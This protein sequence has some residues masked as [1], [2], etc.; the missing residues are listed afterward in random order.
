MQT[1]TFT[2]TATHARH[3]ASK[4]AADLKRLQRIYGVGSPSDSEIGEYQEE[5]AM[6]LD[7]GYLGTVTYGFKRNGKWVVALKYEAAGGSLYGGDDDPGGIR[8]EADISGTHFTSF[9]SYSLSWS[10]LSLQQREEFENSLPF[11]RIAGNEP[12]IENGEWA[13]GRYYR[14]GPLGVQ[15]SLINRG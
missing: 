13:R 15:R 3:V 4:V 7:K 8:I 9:L 14:S 10:C 5:L 1:R 11:R 12:E 6:L 2:H